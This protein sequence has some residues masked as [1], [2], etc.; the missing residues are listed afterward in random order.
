ML[1]RIRPREIFSFSALK[2]RIKSATNCLITTNSKYKC[3]CRCSNVLRALNPLIAAPLYA[4]LHPSGHLSA[5]SLLVAAVE[6]SSMLGLQLPNVNAPLLLYKACCE[7]ALPE[8]C[9]YFVLMP[10][11][12]AC[13]CA[14]VHLGGSVWVNA[15]KCM[16]LLRMCGSAFVWP[17]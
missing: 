4:L 15:M 6:L 7:L 2:S 5:A 17:L 13:Q 1:C 3:D 14:C 9:V 12:C 11:C 10:V 8:V 16:T